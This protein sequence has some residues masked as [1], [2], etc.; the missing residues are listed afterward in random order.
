MSFSLTIGWE[1][2]IIVALLLWL[3]FGMFFFV[4]AF[5]Y[6]GKKSRWYTILLVLGGPVIWITEFKEWQHKKR[7]EEKK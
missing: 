7:L 3:V 5:N 1:P 6:T 2:A 4:V